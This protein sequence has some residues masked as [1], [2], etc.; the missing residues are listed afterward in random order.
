MT[1]LCWVSLGAIKVSDIYICLMNHRA[2]QLERALMNIHPGI[3]P[4]APQFINW[5]MADLP[6]KKMNMGASPTR[7]RR[8]ITADYKNV[9]VLNCRWGD[10]GSVFIDLPPFHKESASNRYLCALSGAPIRPPSPVLEENERPGVWLGPTSR[11][12]LWFPV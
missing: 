12:L 4:R 5:I 2:W 9:L 8:T 11:R 1:T 7:R 10:H 3:L 6:F